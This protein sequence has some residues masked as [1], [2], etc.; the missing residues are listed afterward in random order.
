MPRLGV[1]KNE[2]GV[3]IAARPPAAQSTAHQT[4]RRLPGRSMASRAFYFSE[5]QKRVYRLIFCSIR[6]LSRGRRKVREK[7]VRP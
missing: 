4:L 3:T 5:G 1:V 7:W 6:T 2:T